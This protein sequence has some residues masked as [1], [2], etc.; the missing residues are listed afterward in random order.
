MFNHSAISRPKES[1]HIHEIKG[2]RDNIHVV[3]NTGIEGIVQ[4]QRVDCAC[5]AC[6]SHESECDQKNFVDE[7][8]T[9]NLLKPIQGGVVSDVSGEFM[10]F[11]DE[12]ECEIN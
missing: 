8:I 7:W 5:L 12:D 3:R 1:P 4:Y 2:C 11:G 10:E 6:T 9:V